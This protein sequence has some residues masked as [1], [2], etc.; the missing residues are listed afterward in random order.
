MGNRIP[1]SSFGLG[2]RRVS[3]YPLMVQ[4]R[5]S[6]LVDLLLGN[7]MVIGDAEFL[8]YIFFEILKTSNSDDAHGK[9]LFEKIKVENIF[10]LRLAQIICEASK[11]FDALI[12]KE[13]NSHRIIFL[14]QLHR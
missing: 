12:K 13:K 6:K 4:C 7:P 11:H 10:F 5:R 2:A 3:V 1:K 9:S 14:I 8:T